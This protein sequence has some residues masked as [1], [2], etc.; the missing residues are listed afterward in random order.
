MGFETYAEYDGLGLAELVRRG[1]VAPEEL[2]DAAVS[3][4]ERHNPALNAVVAI[5]RDHALDEI[6]QGLSPGPFKGV[7]FLV[8]EFGMHF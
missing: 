8:K 5:M 6:K 2:V 1:E 3:T 7:P 4:I